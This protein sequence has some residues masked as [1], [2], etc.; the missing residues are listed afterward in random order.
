MVS[1]ESSSFR[2]EVGTS[3]TPVSI[4]L[5]D[6]QGV[7]IDD[8][9]TGWSVGI[10]FFAK[11]AST[12]YEFAAKAIDGDIL[13]GL[14]NRLGPD[15][16][17]LSGWEFSTIGGSVSGDPV[18]LSFNVGP[19]NAREPLAVWYYNGADWTEYDASDAIYDGDHLSFTV[20]GFSGY[21]VTGMVVPEPSTLA[22]LGTG[23][24]GLLACIRRRRP[25]A[26]L[27]ET[28]AT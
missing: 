7:L 19:A 8:A 23:V 13:A 9:T 21:A 14:E 22:L 18:Y 15:D 11:P 12:P 20:T 1:T 5:A 17:V 24:V 3:G 16:A 6:K 26:T 25:Q 2:V 27:S 10:S 28:R 4:D